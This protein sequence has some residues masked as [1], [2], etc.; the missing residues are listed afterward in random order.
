[1]PT[2]GRGMRHQAIELQRTLADSR[3]REARGLQIRLR[4]AAEAS[5]V[6]SIPIRPR[7]CLATLTA[8]HFQP[9]NF[10]F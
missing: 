1:M 7:Q 3:E 8:Q 6:G 10:I 2:D 4:D 9:P 5:W